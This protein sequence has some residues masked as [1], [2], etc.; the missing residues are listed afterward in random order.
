MNPRGMLALVLRPPKSAK[1]TGSHHW[2][3]NGGNGLDQIQAVR[4]I[5]IRPEDVLSKTEPVIL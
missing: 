5:D 4:K 1:A 3:V 2:W